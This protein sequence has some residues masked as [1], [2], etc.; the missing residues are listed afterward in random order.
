MRI[1]RIGRAPG[2]DYV[3][4]NPSVSS[5]HAEIRIMDN[6]EMIFVD[7]STNGSVVD[8]RFVHNAYCALL[9]HET[10]G[11]PGNISVPVS[12]I[13]QRPMTMW[14]PMPAYLASNQPAN[15]PASQPS[16]PSSAQPSAYGVPTKP[17]MDFGET[18]SYYFHHYTDFSGRARRTEYWFIVLWNLIFGIIPV[19]NILWALATLI[20]GLALSVRRLHDIGKSGWW[21]LI[22]LIPIVGAIV[23]F[24]FSVMD[25]EPRTNEYGPSPKYDI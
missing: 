25:S 5:N 2:N 7:H 22:A 17:A 9:G 13:I 12:E 1:I 14:D 19:V 24:I 21:L 8:Q 3:V 6:G 18:L 23:L 16:N 10:I 15:Q 20:P 4:N 11:L